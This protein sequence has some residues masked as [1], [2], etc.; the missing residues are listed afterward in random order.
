MIRI[1]TMLVPDLDLGGIPPSSAGRVNLISGCS[2]RSSVLSSPG[3]GN[4]VPL[5]LS[6]NLRRK[7]ELGLTV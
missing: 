4:I 7:W 2:S 6:C 5:E 3:C 1:R